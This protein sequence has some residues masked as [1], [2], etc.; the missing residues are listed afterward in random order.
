M[1]E[2]IA[3]SKEHKVR[4]SSPPRSFFLDLTRVAQMIRQTQQEEDENLRRELDG[5]LDSIRSLLFARPPAETAA[6]SSSA[7]APEYIQAPLAPPEDDKEYDQYVRELALDRRAKPKDRTKTEEEL[8]RDEKEAL[9]KA[10][11][12]RLKR[13]RGEESDSEGEQKGGKR[14]QARGRGGD[15]LDDDFYDEETEA[16]LGAGLSG[17]VA[18]KEP[19]EEN[20]EEEDSEDEDGSEEEDS[21]EEDAEDGS[22]AGEFE[23]AEE[24]SGEEDGEEGESEALVQ[25]SRKR[26]SKSKPARKELPYTFPCPETHD[27]LLEIVEDVDEADVP[28]IVKRIRTLHHASLA[29]DNKFKLQV[30]SPVSH[31]ETISCSCLSSG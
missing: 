14:K 30:S 5:E 24:D 9:E 15:D 23:S 7:V 22:V 16:G 29:D 25:S 21:E 6:E 12:R 11:R 31:L 4:Y 13:M 1:A 28:T 27:E 10:E 26:R 8:A 17:D 19:E 3:K 18:M 20:G 2:V